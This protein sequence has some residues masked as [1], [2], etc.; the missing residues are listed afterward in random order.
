M[1]I[2]PEEYFDL[3]VYFKPFSKSSFFQSTL[4][5]N[6]TSQ[7]PKNKEENPINFIDPL[8]GLILTDY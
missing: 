1:I 3:D 6:I 8:N 4:H 7:R 5:I 2:K